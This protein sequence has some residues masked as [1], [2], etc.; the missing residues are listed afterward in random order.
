MQQSPEDRRPHGCAR[1]VFRSQQTLGSFKLELRAVQFVQHRRDL[2][3]EADRPKRESIGHDH[4]DA[5]A[6]LICILAGR[7]GKPHRIEADAGNPTR[8]ERVGELHAVNP[9]SA[10][11]FERRVCA[12]SDREVRPLDRTDAWIQRRLKQIA[13]VRRRVDPGQPGLIEPFITL[14]VLDRDNGQVSADAD[15][16]R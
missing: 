7:W 4:E 10:E 12:T 13:H 6:F 2:H 1:A 15:S 8:V 11:L 16:R 9:R 14:P 5:L 3:A